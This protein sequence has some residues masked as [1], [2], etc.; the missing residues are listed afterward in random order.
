MAVY[1]RA[2]VRSGLV[3][4]AVDVTLQIGRP[5]VRRFAIQ[6]QTLD[7][8]DRDAL[9][10][11]AAELRHVAT[12]EAN[13]WLDGYLPYALSSGDIAGAVVVVICSCLISAAAMLRNRAA[14]W[15][16]VR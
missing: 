1:N 3:D 7:V 9:L 4:F 12:D 2:D 8:V 6:I 5:I 10:G 16:E 13:A 14:R 11:A 15:L